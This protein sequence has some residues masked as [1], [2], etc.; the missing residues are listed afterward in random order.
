MNLNFFA[1]VRNLD[2]LNTIVRAR[3]EQLGVSK[4]T[5]DR[6]AG[7]SDGYFAKISTTKPIKGLGPSTFAP[8]IQALALRIIVIDDDT[9]FEAIKHR[10]TQKNAN[11][12]RSAPT[13]DINLAPRIMSLIFS[14]L[15]RRRMRRL[16]DS[17]TPEQRSE[18]ARRAVRVRWG[19]HFERQMMA[20]AAPG[21]VHAAV[22]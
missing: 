16:N 7:L 14:E 12:D 9:A 3:A 20:R 5:V 10:L 17:R 8:T 19:H 22:P 11:Q 1:E 6:V 18:D 4:S 21:A 15:S 13:P 2:D